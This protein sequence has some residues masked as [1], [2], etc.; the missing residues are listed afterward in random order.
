VTGVVSGSWP[1]AE[2]DPV[3]RLRVLAGANGRA[4]YAERYFDVPLD[5][6]WR[7]ASDLEHELPRLVGGLRSFT[8]A[9]P[10]GPAGSGPPERFTATAV[11][12]LRHRE[13]FDVVLR[14][15]WCLMQSRL[16]VGGMAA[17]AEGSGTRFALMYRPRLPGGAVLRRLPRSGARAGA[18]LDR[19]GGRIGDPR[20]T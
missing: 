18:M 19:L 15:G 5:E 16:L 17:A 4:L 13:R 6:V 1:T 7:I 11:S 8:P 14:P 12:R 9:L 10:A 2:L 20:A 3:R